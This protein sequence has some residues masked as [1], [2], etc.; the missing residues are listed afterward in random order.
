MDT[1]ATGRLSNLVDI[2][3][4]L[5]V[6]SVTLTF[7]WA[8]LIWIATSSYIISDVLSVDPIDWW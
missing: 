5:K 8:S 1:R 7:S 2:L 3:R 6:L 4:R